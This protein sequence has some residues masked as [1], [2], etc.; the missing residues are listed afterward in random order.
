M[1]SKVQY[2]ITNRESVDNLD[3]GKKLGL[4]CFDENENVVVPIE[5][6]LLRFHEKDIALQYTKHIYLDKTESTLSPEFY[7]KLLTFYIYLALTCM[8]YIIFAVTSYFQ[9]QMPQVHLIFHVTSNIAVILLACLMLLLLKNSDLFL[10]NFHYCSSL[11]GI[12]TASY[13]IIGNS[14]ALDSIFK[15]EKS[16]YSMP[17]NLGLIGLV[18]MLRYVHQSNFLYGLLMGT[19]I[20]FE[21]IIT[22]LATTDQYSLQ[23]LN[24]FFILFIFIVLQI[25]DTQQTDYKMKKEFWV[26]YR[27]EK[28]Y[29]TSLSM[30]YEEQ[31]P[32][33][34]TETEMLI[35]SCEKIKRTIKDARS[36]IIFKE[37]KNKLKLAQIELEVVKQ[38][39]SKAGFLKDVKIEQHLDIDPEDREFISQNFIDISYITQERSA[40]SELTV[41]DLKESCQ[42]FPFSHYGIDKL[43]S[44]LS[45]L[46]K[47]WSF[48]IW[49][50]HNATGQ[51]ASISGKYLFEKWNLNT[52]LNQDAAITDEFFERLENGY[53]NNPYHNACHAADVLHTSLFFICQSNLSKSLNQLDIISCII[54]ALGH[55]L[56]HPAVTNRFLVNNHDRI[57]IKYNDSSV[58]ENMHCAKTFKLLNTPGLDVFSKLIPDDYSKSR[59]MIIEMIL[60]TD[61]SRHFEILGKFRTRVMTLS[62]MD[63]TVFEDKCQVVSMGLKCADIGHSSK[64]Y[65]LHEKWSRLVCEEFFRQGDLEKQRGQP[66]SMYCDRETTDIS[67]SQAGFIKNICLPLYEVWCFYLKSET[68]EKFALSQLKNNLEFWGGRKKRRSTVKEDDRFEVSERLKRVKSQK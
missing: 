15:S 6:N 28:S 64:D 30:Q 23:N 62:N 21:Y 40:K 1:S 29:K 34:R 9:N 41:F 37:V 49:F 16:Q 61:M 38:R 47:N 57:A 26:Q 59:K 32:N 66:V 58:L 60:E 8:C 51:S 68:V 50:V 44:V 5:S 10:S 48:D 24:E 17:L 27:D 31:G 20:I 36:V 39:I 12:F 53:L 35:S 46:G 33:F 18:I 3:E 25:V 43:E 52:Y 22:L 54:A 65:D 45:Q 67:K 7:L 63:I 42:N 56:G 4:E 13:F 14:E 11:I 2:H 19:V 55:D